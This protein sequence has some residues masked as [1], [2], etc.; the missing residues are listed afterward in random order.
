MCLR[1]EPR[2]NWHTVLK[3][4]LDFGGR[5]GLKHVVL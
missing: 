2:E 5:V 4:A 3:K 1:I